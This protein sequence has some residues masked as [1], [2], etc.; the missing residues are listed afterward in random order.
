M[1]LAALV[2]SHIHQHDAVLM[3]RHGAVC[4]GENLL[5]AFCR[6]ETMEHMA[7]ITKSARDMGQVQ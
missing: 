2:G 1:D 5:E 6:L 7:L 4:V 3:D